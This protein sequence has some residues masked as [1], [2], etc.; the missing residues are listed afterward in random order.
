MARQLGDLARMVHAELDD[1][2]T[3]DRLRQTS[4]GAAAQ[5]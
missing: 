4:A 3:M 5:A 1:G 2:G